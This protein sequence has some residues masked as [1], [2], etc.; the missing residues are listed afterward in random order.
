MKTRRIR[1]PFIVLAAVPAIYYIALKASEAVAIEYIHPSYIL[2]FSLVWIVMALAI[3]VPAFPDSRIART[4]CRVL[5]GGKR[6][7]ITLAALGG[8]FAAS[9]LGLAVWIMTPAGMSAEQSANAKSSNGSGT[10]VTRAG[11]PAYLLVLGGGLLPDGRVSALLSSRLDA[12][13]T[14][15]VRHPGV[16]VIVTGG[17]GKGTPFPES[18]AMSKYIAERAGVPETSILAEDRSKDTIQNMA[19]SRE[20]IL[21]NEGSTE[22]AFPKIAVLTNEFHIRRA[23]LLARKAGYPDPAGIAVR[24]PALQLP[25][26]LLREVGAWWKLGIRE[27]ALA[28]TGRTLFGK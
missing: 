5:W 13:A 4:A 26:A 17:Q 20:I 21:R 8:I 6:R 28:V 9:S 1:L 3:L 25:Q 18:V 19:N 11:A 27:A 12:A 7:R 2:N 22:Q 24:S 16:R 23:L 10:V 14:Y 15:L